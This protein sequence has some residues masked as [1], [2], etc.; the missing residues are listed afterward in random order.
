LQQVQADEMRIKLQGKLVLWVAMAVMVGSR[1]WLGA[2]ISPRR[3][4]PLIAALARLVR[5]W[6]EAD[7]A[8]HHL[9]RL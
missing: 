3:D 8:L 4:V 2:V 5:R 6:G 7:G 1:L 9:R